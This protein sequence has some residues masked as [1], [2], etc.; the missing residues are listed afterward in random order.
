[1]K[2]PLGPA[3][4]CFL[5]GSGLAM[6]GQVFDTLG[7]PTNGSAVTS[8]ILE[9]GV[10]YQIRASG[11]FSIGG[12]GDGPGDAEYA[13]LSALPGSAIDKCEDGTGARLVGVFAADASGTLQVP[14]NAQANVC[15]GLIQ[16]VDLGTCDVSN[17]EQLQ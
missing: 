11:T 15:G 12:P 13:D 6:A 4:F 1:M 17:L 7:I 9:A 16:V 8:V 5:I 3:V 14:G 10:T 2:R